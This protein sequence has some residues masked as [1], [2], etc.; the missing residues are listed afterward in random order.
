MAFDFKLIGVEDGKRNLAKYRTML[1]GRCQDGTESVAEFIIAETQGNI[2]DQ[3]AIRTGELFDSYRMTTRGSRVKSTRRSKKSYYKLATKTGFLNT[4]SDVKL[5]PGI[6]HSDLALN[7]VVSK[8][9]GAVVGTTAP[10]AVFVEFGTV[11]MPARPHFGPAVEKARQ[12]MERLMAD[13]AK[14]IRRL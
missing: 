9:I 11:K 10:H 14:K 1:K 2:Y 8:P 5:A 12:R 7:A 6:S 4:A 3:R 13:E